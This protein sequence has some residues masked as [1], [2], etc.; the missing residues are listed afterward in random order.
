MTTATAKNQHAEQQLA[1]LGVRRG[2]ND[3]IWDWVKDIAQNV[4]EYMRAPAII[5]PLID[6]PKLSATILEQ[7]NTQAL[8]DHINLLGRDVQTYTLRLQKLYARHSQR[9]GSSADPDDLMNGINISQD[10]RAFMA[11]YESVVM[12]TILDILTIF[13]QA[14]LDTSSI[15][16]VANSGLVYELWDRG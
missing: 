16:A 5:I 9:N 12:P 4:K 14:G 13:E 1:K 2:K 8:M 7:G 15:R 3:R 6:D 10:Y 11:S